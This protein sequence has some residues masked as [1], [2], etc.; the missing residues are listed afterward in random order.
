MRATIGSNRG[1]FV[2]IPRWESRRNSPAKL[3]ASPV[4]VLVL[5][6]DVVVVVSV[7]LLVLRH[8]R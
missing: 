5:A 2:I 6:A 3:R 4:V 8:L 1:G 7:V